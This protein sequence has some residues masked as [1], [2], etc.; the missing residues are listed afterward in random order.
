MQLIQYLPEKGPLEAGEQI[1]ALEQTA[2]PSGADQAVFPSAPHTYVTSFAFFE[3]GKAVCH[4]GIR[5]ALLLH[6]GVN[7][8]AYGISEVVTHPSFRHQ[9]LATRLLGL[10]AEFIL[11]QGADISIFTCAPSRV[12]FYTRNGWCPCPN[13]CL[14]GGTRQ[15]PFRS[16]LLG[17][18]TMI[19]FISDRAIA[20]RQAFEQTDIFLELG[21]CQ[22]W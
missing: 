16:D 19:R 10:S 4:V 1:I 17:L 3:H 2:W 22:L 15:Q 11:S 20:H 5:K 8:L 6:N 21:Q 9:G 12:P 18:I 13:S 14:V 7:Y